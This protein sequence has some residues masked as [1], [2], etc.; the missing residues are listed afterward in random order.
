MEATGAV[1]V[2]PFDDLDVIAGQ[3]T[4]G[5]EI[6]EETEGDLTVVVPVGGGG[7][8]AGIAAA[9]A[10]ATPASGRGVHPGGGC[11]GRRRPHD[12]G[13]LGGRS[14]GRTGE[15]VDHG[16][17]H[18][19]GQLQRAD[20]RPRQ[21]LRR[22][23]VTV[24]EEEISRAMLLLLER[25]KRWSSP[26]ARR[27]WPPSLAGRI[28]GDGPVVA[29]LSGGNVDP[30][31]LT[32]LI[33]HGL[34][35]AGR[36]LT[37]RIVI[38]DRVGA[39]AA[40]TGE[41]A[42]LAAQR[43]RRGAP[44]QRRA[45][46]VDEVEVQVTVETRDARPPPEVVSAPPRRPASPPNRSSRAGSS[47]SRPPTGTDRGEQAGRPRRGPGRRYAGHLA[48]PPPAPPHLDQRPDQR[49]DHLMAERG[50]RYLEVA[51]SPAP[52]STQRASRTMRTRDACGAWSPAKG[53][54][55]VLTEQGIT[56]QAHRR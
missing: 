12:Y 7:L 29:V 8:I 27:P 48:G 38:A 40:L 39:L 32:K 42:R 41:L 51:G 43:A 10:L 9:I 36:Y 15:D 16:R 20:P 47:G 35:A 53:R 33:E 44:P 26:P 18:R 50:G 45:L 37:L 21:G 28:T 49:T 4:I 17:R 11:R 30:L 54:E 25:A 13:R 22:R 55:V 23:G 31:L 46:A 52:A 14:S 19:R 6:L 34:S 56:R 1:Y 2:P 24:D 5:A 3:G